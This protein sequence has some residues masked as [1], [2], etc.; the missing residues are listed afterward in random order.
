MYSNNILLVILILIVVNTGLI[1]W[2]EFIIH[3]KHLKSHSLNIP[4]PIVRRK[5][6]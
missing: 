4:Y 3:S 6:I 1:E 5:N 2:K